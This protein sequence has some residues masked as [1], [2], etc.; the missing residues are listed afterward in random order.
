M[1]DTFYDLVDPDVKKIRAIFRWGY[2]HA[3]RTDIDKLD[4]SVSF[5]REPTDKPFSET[6]KLI[7]S[8]AVGYFRIVILGGYA[9]TRGVVENGQVVSNLMELFIRSIQVG[10]VEY[11]IFM[12]LRADRL[13]D[14]MKKYPL[15]RL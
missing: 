6:V 4:C 10:E 8:K 15:R 11:F 9:H 13:E 14:L 12:Y 2:R 3:L 5:R 1:P 7:T